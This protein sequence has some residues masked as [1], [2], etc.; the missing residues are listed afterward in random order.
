VLVLFS[1]V[2]LPVGATFDI[3]MKDTAKIVDRTGQAMARP[4][5]GVVGTLTTNATPADAPSVLATWPADQEDGVSTTPEIVVVFDRPVDESTVNDASFQVL[6]DDDDPPFDALPEPLLVGGVAQDTRVFLWRSTSGGLPASL[7]EGVH[8]S[9]SLSGGGHAIEDTGGA[10]LPLTVFEFDTAPFSAPVSGS[11]TSDPPDAIG[12]DNISGPS[13]LAV[14]ALLSGAQQGDVLVVTIFGTNPDVQVNPPLMALRREIPIVAPFD[15]F[16]ATAEELDL[17]ASTEPFRARLA[18]GTLAMALQLQRG[19]VTSPLKLLDVDPRTPGAQ[20]P[21]LDTVAPVLVGLSTSGQVATSMRSDVRDV[22]LVGRASESISRAAV[23]TPLGD[24]TIT[25]GVIPAVVGAD[26]S[27]LFVAAP[28][29]LGVLAPTDM[30]LDFNLAIFDRALNS[31]SVRSDVLDPADGY[32]QVGASGPGNALPGGTI[33]VEVFDATTLAP[34]ALANVHV[35]ENLGGTVVPIAGGL[36]TTDGA[37][38]AT[39]PAAG[40]GETIL[41]VEKA[42]FDVF[43][44]DGVPTDRLGVPLT[45]SSLAAATASGSVGPANQIVATQ[46]NAYTRAV[47]DS[48]RTDLDPT[49]APVATCSLDGTD[50]RFECPFGPLP[51]HAR[52]IGAQS[53]ITVLVPPNPFLYSALTFLKTADLFLPIPPVEPGSDGDSHLPLGPLLDAGTLDPEERPI[54]AP[55]QMLSTLAWPTLAED[56]STA[57]EA[58]SPGMP[59]AVAVGRGLAFDDGL[60]VGTWNVVAAYPG[61]ADGI[62]DVPIDVLGR[63]VTQGTIDADLLLRVE[64]V[65]P[66]G[67]RGGVR[68]RFSLAS[69]GLTVPAAP[70]L[71]PNPATPNAGGMSFDLTF[72][73]VLPD[74]LSAPGRGLYR[75]VLTDSAGRRWTSFRPDPPDAAGPNVVLHVPNLAGTFPLAPGPLDGRISAWSWP[76]LDLGEFL[77]TDVEREHDLFVHSIASSFTPP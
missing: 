68:P 49:F 26:P 57:V 72:P 9:V 38:F 10:F 71:G 45:P 3:V 39:V 12:I 19:D 47:V 31:V 36:A 65:D 2:S 76:G 27:G 54:E 58:T 61:S 8:V 64:V 15:S 7:G 56:P 59:E 73:D 16:T 17:V 35:A 6:V 30:P 32:V 13:T 52:Q 53:A 24:N 14:Q 18:D 11:I 43:T 70:A 77:W 37:G 1:P 4:A 63:L 20:G 34:V 23:S 50:D 69:G 41:T 60:P 28:V 22:V 40:A 51:V 33:T 29:R 5:N 25:P 42:G 55:A 44:F 66:A 21:I 75:V 46:L 62:Q 67:N 48:R 74:V